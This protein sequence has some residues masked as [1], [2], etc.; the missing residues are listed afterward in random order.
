MDK[1]FNAIITAITTV[2]NFSKYLVIPTGALLFFPEKCLEQMR[3]IEIKNNF[4]QWIAIIFLLIISV[5]IIDFFTCIINIFKT[6]HRFKNGQK[7][8]DK[9]METM[10]ITDKKIIFEVYKN[11]NANLPINNA[12]VEKL[13]AQ[14]VITRPSIGVPVSGLNFSYCLQPWVIEWLKN[15]PNYFFEGSHQ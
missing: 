10:N 4:G 2:K 9:I 14:K 1:T 8:F 11:D 12:S 13:T 15:H 6:K 5:I 7:Y 3:L